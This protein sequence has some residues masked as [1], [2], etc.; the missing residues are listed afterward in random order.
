MGGVGKDRR[1][2]VE[3]SVVG[4]PPSDRMREEA[5]ELVERLLQADALHRGRAEELIAAMLPKAEV[6]SATAVLQARLNAAAREALLQ[7]IPAC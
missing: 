6:P 1:E 2:A 5:R 4:H 3:T 7:G